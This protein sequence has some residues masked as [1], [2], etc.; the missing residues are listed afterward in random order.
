VLPNAPAPAFRGLFGPDESILAAKTRPPVLAY[1]STPFRGL[2]VLLYAFER[3][4]GFV[5][6]VRL[7]VFS[8]MAVYQD[9]AAD[10]AFRTLYDWCRR[11]DGVEYVGALPQPRLAR[12]LRS[13]SLL[14]YPSTFAETYCITAIEAMAA[15]CRVVTTALGALP[16]TTAGF[17]RL[18]S[19]GDDV[20]ALG[21]AFAE[22]TL[23]ALADLESQTT[24]A[25]LRRQVDYVDRDCSWPAR[26][27]QWAAW[28]ASR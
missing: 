6:E 16:E 21:N 10:E 19:H 8:S 14:A 26:A 13:V 2:H 18:V 4:R 24:E 7:K 3:I 17:A 15:G 28:L 25:E 11:L 1:T 20:R 12:E 5:P 9:P 23:E 22:A 27:R